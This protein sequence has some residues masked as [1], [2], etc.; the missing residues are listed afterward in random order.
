MAGIE[1]RVV[2]AVSAEVKRVSCEICGGYDDY[3]PDGGVAQIHRDGCPNWILCE[4]GEEDCEECNPDH[5]E[6]PDEAFVLALRL[7]IG[8]ADRDDDAVNLALEAM[9]KECEACRNSVWFAV[10]RVME[11]HATEAFANHLREDLLELLDSM[12]ESEGAEDE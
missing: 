1:P 10:L 6:L 2:V 4:C 9:P 12:E 3:F 11:N 7:L 5:G 8:A